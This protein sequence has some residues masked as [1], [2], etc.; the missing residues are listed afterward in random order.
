LAKN[1]LA[2]KE[3]WINET[4]APPSNDPQEPPWS[5]ARFPI[6]QQE[7]AAFILQEFALAFSA[8]AA[9]VEVYKLRNSAD[10]PESIEPFGLLR[11]DDSRR[12]AFGAYRVATTYLSGFRTAT[13]SRSG[14]AVAVTFDRGAQT[15]TVLWN[16]G[17]RPLRVTVRAILPEGKL[18]DVTGK[19][20]P[21]RA[22]GG[23]YRIDLPPATCRTGGRCMI[24]GAPLLLVEDGPA[25]GRQ[26]LTAS[27]QR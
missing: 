11:A 26:A 25:Q 9:R 2:D 19:I 4:N 7:Q 21:V 13:R 10:H 1:G 3:I 14:E 27:A 16:A 18:V 24:G 22:T 15:T 23:A 17:R 5:P 12:P 20:T 8:G 6:S